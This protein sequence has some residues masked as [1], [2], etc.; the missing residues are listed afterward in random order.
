MNQS[1]P[2]PKG[3]ED[4]GQ[5]RGVEPGDPCRT[6]GRWLLP[7]SL[8]VGILWWIVLLGLAAQTANPVTLNFRQIAQAEVI[9]LGRVVQPEIGRVDVVRQWLRDEPLPSPLVLG[10]LDR[11]LADPGQSYLIPLSRAADGTLMVTRA[12]SPAAGRNARPTTAPAY[13][14]PASPELIQRLESLCQRLDRR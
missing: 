3:P 4:G 1:Q 12:R 13:I 11:R 14:Y 7:L 6:T 2:I 9:V 8:V 10:N 5:R